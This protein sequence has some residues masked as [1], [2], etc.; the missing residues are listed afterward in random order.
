M[1]IGVKSGPF[2]DTIKIAMGKKF[3]YAIVADMAFFASLFILAN[4]LAAASYASSQSVLKLFLLSLV[5][6]TA[7]LFIYSFFK[8]LALFLAR[9]SFEKYRLDFERLGKFFFLNVCIFIIL[10]IVFFMLSFLAANIK[11]G[12]VPFAALAILFLYAIIAYPWLNMVH[13]F[14]YEGKNMLESLKHGA[15]SLKKIRDYYGAYLVIASA[16][17]LILALFG[18]FGNA[19]KGTVFQNYSSLLKYGDMYTI[20]FVHATGVIV[21]LAILFNRFYFYR[22][23]KEKLK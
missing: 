2:L 19:L 10:F 16:I 12:V 8:Y 18:I 3:F 11:E 4:L 15:L 9:S 13:V 20:I 1:R 23:V 5:Y 22:I 21:Y 6:Y 17:L 14:F 7:L